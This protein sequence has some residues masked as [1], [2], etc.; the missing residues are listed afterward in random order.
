MFQLILKISF[1]CFF[2]FITCDKCD[3]GVINEP[4]YTFCESMGC[5]YAE[6]ENRYDTYD[7]ALQHCRKEN[8]PFLK[9]IFSIYF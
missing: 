5:L 2:T 7:Q 4:F 1:F 6:P 3:P 8:K 9:Y